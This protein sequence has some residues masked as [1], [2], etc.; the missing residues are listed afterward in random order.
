MRATV[1]GD[2]Q[3]THRRLLE[4]LRPHQLLNRGDRLQADV[5]LLSIGDH[6]DFKPPTGQTVTDV[7]REGIA[8]LEWL[9]S[10]PPRQARILMGNHD[11]CRVMELHRISDADFAAAR[12]LGADPAFAT[13]F[14]DIPTPGLALRDFSSFSTAQRWLIQGL[15]LRGRMVLAATGL[16]CSGR[17]ILLTHAG[18]TTRELTLLG[19]PDERRPAAI[20]EALNAFLQKRLDRVR[21]DWLAGRSAPLDLSPVHIAGTTGAEGGGLLYHRPQAR[22][23]GWA[24]QGARRYHPS[25]LPDGLLQACGHT[26]HGKM[27]ELLDGVPSIPDGALR[28]LWFDGE[29]RYTAGL[30][31]RADALWMVDSGLNHAPAPALLSLA[32][33]S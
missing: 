13:K 18:V 32:A 20:A 10:H 9:E 21:S 30:I 12:Q 17:A 8:I 15:L 25:T 26:Q 6:F 16:T 2:P 33:F 3:T 7:G 23:E 24:A 4:A 11:A 1:I 5:Q 29:I 27:R 31:E 19:I 28:S 22:L 14:P